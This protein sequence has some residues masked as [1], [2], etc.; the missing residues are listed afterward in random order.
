[1]VITKITGLSAEWSSGPHL[2]PWAYLSYFLP[3]PT[4]EG[5]GESSMLDTWLLAKINLA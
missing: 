3:H 1:M 2:D 5:E 4:E